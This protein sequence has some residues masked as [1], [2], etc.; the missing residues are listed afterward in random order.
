MGE[1][2]RRLVQCNLEFKGSI[3]NEKTERKKYERKRK[4]KEKI[5]IYKEKRRKKNNKINSSAL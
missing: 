3:K 5:C 4:E 1:L 2:P